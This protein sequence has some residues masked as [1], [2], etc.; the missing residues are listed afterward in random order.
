[1]PPSGNTTS[2]PLSTK[3]GGIAGDDAAPLVPAL[4]LIWCTNAPERVG[5]VALLSDGRQFLGREAKELDDATFVRMRPGRNEAAGDLGGETLSRRQLQIDVSDDEITI[6]NIGR[7]DV[8]VN[9]R[10]IAK[11]ERVRVSPGEIIA[12]DAHCGMMVTMRPAAIPKTA[13]IG[14]GAFGEPDRHGIVGESAAIWELR[15]R[16]AFV[17]GLDEHTLALG[18]TGVGKE[19]VARAI[20]RMSRRARGPFVERS[21]PSIP[22]GLT[23]A[24]AFGNAK[25]WPNPGMP[26]SEGL[27]GMACGGV[28]FLDEIGEIPKE[29]QAV[30]LRV[31]DPDGSYQR[32]G[33]PKTRKADLRIVAATNRQP[34]ALK[35]DFA[36]RFA[37][38]LE[39]P[40]FD[41]RREDIPLL[42]RALMLRAWAKS[43]GP[44]E[45][46]IDT[47][48]ARPEAKF[49]PAFVA[50]L[51]QRDYPGNTRELE[52][53][54]LAA[55]GASRDGVVRVT[56]AMLDAPPARSAPPG[57][58]L[59]EDDVRAALDVNQQK[60][61]RAADA[62]GV[63][64]YVLMR[65]MK[66]YGLR[67]AA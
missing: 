24:E 6:E 18:E 8:T 61:S 29:M 11:G 64:R 60:V 34:S 7:R 21:A 3:T 50:Y 65:L 33:D 52:S 26:E 36:M 28:L 59:T 12:I 48:G 51:V 46:F 53:V 23:E 41:A 16:I 47:S 54:L 43:P 62:L 31:L 45:K 44:M 13:D 20:H 35:F 49:D 55:V 25:N 14:R 19:L 37:L 1:M 27:V 30:L 56:R 17:A 42:A 63:T 40:P 39:V 38:R 57:A 22:R 32:L 66:K 2:D 5:E 15:E 67:R 58:P 9:G 10:K 4:T